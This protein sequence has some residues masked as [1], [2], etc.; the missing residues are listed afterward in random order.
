MRHSHQSA[1]K[2]ID[3][4][5]NLR[6]VFPQNDISIILVLVGDIIV[7][8]IIV[9]IVEMV[10][11]TVMEEMEMVTVVMAMVATV[12][13]TVAVVMEEVENENTSTIP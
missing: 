2:D 12:V 3:L 11:E 6:V 4:I 8:G 9:Q 5:Q 1:L 7:A 13:A 10:M